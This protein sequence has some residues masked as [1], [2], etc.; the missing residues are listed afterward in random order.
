M[1][2]TLD[3]CPR[4][5]LFVPGDRSDMLE[6]ASRY[7]AHAYMPD[8]ESAVP[9]EQKGRARQVVGAA[10][11]PL[12]A[13]GRIV[14]PRV[15]QFDSGLIEEDLDVVVR[16]QVHAI[17]ISNVDGPLDIQRVDEMITARERRAEMEI[18]SVGVV[19]FIESAGALVRAYDIACAA[20]RV[21]G[22]AFGAEDYCVDMGIS[23][24]GSTRRA[25]SESE[26]AGVRHA[27]STLAV[28][29]R[30]AERWALDTPYL[31]LHDHEGLTRD[32]QLGRAL[33]F[34]GKLAIHPAQLETINGQFLPTGEE[35]YQAQR[36]V[37]AADNAAQQGRGVVNLDG[38]MVDAPIVERAR[39]ILAAA[40]GDE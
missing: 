21:V 29:A 39:R 8:L 26:D 16:P 19:A 30:A 23:R 17:A 33:G 18:G 31:R 14:I 38:E 37:K 27:R 12:A 5:V 36:I 4:S 6:K 32:V 40:S 10:V 25:G 20:R 24:I 28:A 11:A 22:L 2:Q 7:D 35:V 13:R 34:G 3:D 9:G 1:K 15:N